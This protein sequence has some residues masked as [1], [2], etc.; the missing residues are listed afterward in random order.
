MEYSEDLIA[1]L[2]QEWKC[3]G[4]SDTIIID[5]GLLFAL[6]KGEYFS[7]TVM[8][9][10]NRVNIYDEKLSGSAWSIHA[11]TLNNSCKGI[12]ILGGEIYN[13]WELTQEIRDAFDMP[14]FSSDYLRI[15][16]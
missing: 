11:L 12:L 7:L 5:H 3:K 15:A 14:L 16:C 10:D 13:P 4:Y 1:D 2:L 9:E 6:N 8:K